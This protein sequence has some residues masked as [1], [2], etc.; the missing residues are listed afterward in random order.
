MNSGKIHIKYI[1]RR[2]TAALLCLCISLFSFTACS[3]DPVIIKLPL[4]SLPECLDPQISDSL[5][6]E[7]IIN[8]C[9]EGLVR[10]NEKGE[11]VPGVAKSWNISGNGLTYTFNLDTKARWHLPKHLDDILGKDYEKKF[12]TR[13]TASDFEF[14]LRRAVDP[15]TE[16]PMANA[17]IS[18]DG[19]KE[20]MNG[21]AK[22]DT[23][24]VSAVNDTTLVIHLS[25]PGINLLSALALPVSM[26]CNEKFFNATVGRYGLENELILSNGP[27]YIKKIDEETGITLAKNDDYK[28]HFEAV[29]DTAK[30]V[31][32]EAFV[33]NGS[34]EDEEDITVP[35]VAQLMLLD[36]GGYDIGNIT[37]S[38]VRDLE[39]SAE[40][41][42]YKNTV[43]LL[44]LNNSSKYFKDKNLRLAVMHAT[45]ISLLRKHGQK[46]EGIV[47]ACCDLVPGSS[48]RASS[49]IVSPLKFDFSSAESFAASFTEAFTEE[50]GKLSLPISFV[51]LKE[52]E[53]QV[54]SMLQN[55][56]KLF[57]VSLSVTIETFDSQ[58][59]LNETIKSGSYDAAYTQIT[60]SESLVSDFLNRFSSGNRLNI[61]NLKSDAYDTLIDRIYNAADEAALLKAAK[62]AEEFL[63]NSASILP[64]AEEGSYLAVK[65]SAKEVTVRPSGTVYALYTSKGK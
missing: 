34:N 20:I 16:S 54:K 31:M 63:I 1:L 33:N 35:P 46:A 51:C 55:W 26:P 5:D 43:K 25:K 57:G 18:I 23:L 28:G 21:S 19:A 27:Y 9:F 50:N 42:E 37:S 53:E 56:Q 3:K 41:N 47:P 13:V 4:N 45:D 11:I 59:D 29:A 62:E 52:D 8:N 12:D 30:F 48:Y 2:L 39:K 61:I 17:L 6:S 65:K 58:E 22:S 38:D 10:I 36:E 32:P 64:V 60:A 49:N 44:C 24:G 40:I 15:A 14:A 7:N